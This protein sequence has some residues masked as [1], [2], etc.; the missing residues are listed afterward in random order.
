[1]FHSKNIKKLRSMFLG[2]ET[3]AYPQFN[4]KIYNIDINPPPH[5]FDKYI[6]VIMIYIVNYLQHV[7][8]A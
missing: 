2:Y 4:A 7:L 5:L 1:M 8:V 3:N 6:M